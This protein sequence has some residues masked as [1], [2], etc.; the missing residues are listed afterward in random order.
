M[1]ALLLRLLVVALLL[2]R[3]RLMLLAVLMPRAGFCC[4]CGPEAAPC[5]AA[6]LQHPS[7]S[8]PAL[9]Q[10]HVG[11]VTGL[12]VSAD[13]T[14]CASISTDKTVKVRRYGTVGPTLI[15]VLTKSAVGVLGCGE[16]LLRPPPGIPLRPHTRPSTRARAIIAGV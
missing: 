11:P 16:R 15:R 5:F 9:L 14:L 13:G 7:R 1:S 4:T 2:L 12:A 8:P 3:L 6:H 10:A